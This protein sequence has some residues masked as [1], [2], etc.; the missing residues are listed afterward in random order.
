MWGVWLLFAGMDGR[1]GSDGCGRVLLVISEWLP[2]IPFV[3]W[4]HY[5]YADLEYGGYP[6]R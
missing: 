4:F 1:S 2:I 6:S 5:S 3:F